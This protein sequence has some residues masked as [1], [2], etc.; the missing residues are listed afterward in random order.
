VPFDATIVASEIAS[1]KPAPRH[2]EEFFAQTGAP[3]EG[4][5]HVAASHFHDVVPARNLGLRTVWINRLD[6]HLAP[7]P[8]RERRDLAGLADVLDELVPA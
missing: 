8:D 4:H 5:V 2:W 6:E 7:A 3:R 1:Y